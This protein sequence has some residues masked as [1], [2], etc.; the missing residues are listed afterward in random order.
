MADGAPKHIVQFVVVGAVRV[1][2]VE[3]LRVPGTGTRE[4]PF[5]QVDAGLLDVVGD[6]VGLGCEGV[7]HGASRRVELCHG[8]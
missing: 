2:E 4:V 1:G 3:P 7:E 5:F 8:A 6:Q